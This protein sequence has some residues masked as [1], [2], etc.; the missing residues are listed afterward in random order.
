MQRYTDTYIFNDQARFEAIDTLRDSLQL[1]PA[2]PEPIIDQAQSPLTIG[3]E[4]EMTWRHAFAELATKW[5]T[6]GPTPRSFEPSDIFN[7]FTKE[8]GSHDKKL[9]PTLERISEVIPRVGF[10]AYWEFSFLPSKNIQVT[11]SELA[12][13]YEKE[14]LQ[15][16]EDYSMHMTVSGIDNDR[17]AFAFLCG[18][19]LNGGT[20]PERIL[21]ATKTTNGA[22]AYKGNGGILKR[23]PKELRGDDK[24]AYEF[25]T[26]LGRSQRQIGSA[27]FEAAKIGTILQDP[28]QWEAF[29]AS[30]EATLRHQGLETKRWSHPKED[31]L[32]WLKYAQLLKSTV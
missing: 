18:L 27:L 2:K 20:T 31:A 21:Q 30:I 25:R 22:W 14:I 28:S 10:D 9:R 17:D 5:P 7:T 19:E 8:Y 24:I 15:N 32:P 1:P 6:S 11:L 13:L 4:L 23:E 12:I 29:R 3:I 26:L 16:D